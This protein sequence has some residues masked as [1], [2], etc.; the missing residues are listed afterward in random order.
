MTIKN[1]IIRI[2]GLLGEVKDKD[3]KTYVSKFT[4]IGYERDL[5]PI[6]ESKKSEKSIQFLRDYFYPDFRKIMFLEDDDQDSIRMVCNIEKEVSLGYGPGD[7]RIFYDI[8]INKC[9]VYLFKNQIGLFSVSVSLKNDNY[10]IDELSNILSIVRSFDTPVQN[11]T[12]WMDWIGNNYLSG[13][14]LRGKDVMVDE[15]SGS[16]FKL[17][18]VIDADFDKESRS[19]YLYDLATTSKLGSSKGVGDYAPDPDYVNEIMKNRISFFNNWEA[20]CLFDGFCCVGTNQLDNRNSIKY[21]TWDYTYFR[22]YLYR[23]FFKYNLYR[24]NSVIHHDKEETTKYRDQFEAF[25]NKYNLS[26]ISFNF[27]ANDLFNK[28]GEALELEK[29]LTIF[30]ERINNLS[31]ALQEKRQAK[32]NLL[33]Q[34]VT[35]LSGISSVG[36]IFDILKEVEKW[37]GWSDALFYSVLVIIILIFGGAILFYLMP[38]KVRKWTS[39]IF[40]TK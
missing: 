20:L 34:A 38:E 8:K 22:I 3:L 6:E 25:L 31:T 14:V 9:E 37:L 4:N 28:T 15:Y 29:E 40:G 19:D 24:Y 36:P 17:F 26:H 10:S 12:N 35:V 32:T 27:L 7:N 1:S 39:K 33:L 16:K 2:V 18:T 21:S 23:L 11:Q 5:Y 30:R 13:T